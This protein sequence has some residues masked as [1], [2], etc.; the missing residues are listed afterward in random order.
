MVVAALDHELRPERLP[1]ARAFRRPAARTAGRI[2]GEAG[3]GDQLFQFLGQRRLVITRDGRGEA[4]MM[5]ETLTVI[6]PKQQRADERLAFVIAKAADDA[7]CTAVVLDLLHAVALAR[8]V[9]QVAPLG[10]DAVERGAHPLEP[11]PCVGEL[12]GC[13]REANAPGAAEI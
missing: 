10:D 4:D 6:E 1:L 13:R 8:P 5:Q 11:A 2:A 3:W 7:V 12:G 9:W